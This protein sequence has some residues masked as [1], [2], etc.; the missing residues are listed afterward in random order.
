MNVLELNGWDR[1]RHGG[2][3][4]DPQRL[5]ILAQYIPPSLSSF[6]E[7]ELRRLAGA[8]LEDGTDIP[9]FIFFVLQ[10]VCGFGPDTGSWQRGTQ[11]GPEWTRWAITGE[12]VKPR[13]IWRGKKGGL[14]PVFVDAEKRL[15]IGRGRRTTSQVL[16]WLREGTERLGGLNLSFFVLDEIAGLRPIQNLVNLLADIAMPVSLPHRLFASLWVSQTKMAKSILSGWRCSW[17]L[18]EY[19]RRRSLAISNAVSAKFAALSFEDLCWL[20]RECDFS[21]ASLANEIRASRL[22]VKGFWREDKDKDPELRYTVLTLVAFHDLEEKIRECGGDR[23]K[24]IEAFPNQN[25]GEGWMLPETLRLADYGLGHDERAKEH[26]PVASRLGPRFYD[27]QLVQSPEESWRECHI[28]ARNLLGERGY[29]ELLGEVLANAPE[30]GWAEALTFARELSKKENLLYA[31]EAALGQ[32]PSQSWA[33]R[34]EEAGSV[35]A[36]RG[37]KLEQGDRIQILFGATRRVPEMERSGALS[38]CSDIL[39]SDACRIVMQRLLALEPDTPD[40]PWH[41]LLR[42]SLGPVAYR[43]LVAALETQAHTGVA[44]PSAPYDLTK[45]KQGRLFD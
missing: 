7:R 20:L 27:W 35:M 32:I 4:L 44:E 45:M 24:G 3:L 29:L 31:F 37:F 38:A 1:L 25:D 5:R 21:K 33:S 36:G 15:G 39:D 11:V 9:G 13:Q 8:V 42:E 19:N 34:L 6:H 43:T 10:T 40:G 28:H 18:T 12:G 17:S 16:Q 14:L 41:T 23:D 22:S 2:F 30:G 26:Q